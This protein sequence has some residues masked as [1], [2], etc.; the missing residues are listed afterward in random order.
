LPI[1]ANPTR[2]IISQTAQ[3][4]QAEPQQPTFRAMTFGSTT[5]PSAQPRAPVTQPRQFETTFPQP[6]VPPTDYPAAMRTPYASA[7]TVY[8][9]GTSP[10]FLPLD[11]EDVFQRL[12]KNML[13]G[14][15]AAC[16][17]HLFDYAR[18]VDLFRGA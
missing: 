18:A 1:Y 14:A 13:Q 10:T 12:T 6:V 15:L 11:G 7:T 8:G 2:P 9:G 5:L 4:Q 17:W 16:G 3:A